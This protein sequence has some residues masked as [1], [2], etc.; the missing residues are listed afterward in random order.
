MSH[1]Y[2]GIDCYKCPIDLAIYQR[3]MWELKPRTV[4]V[5]TVRRKVGARSG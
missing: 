2:K 3:L 5:E 4:I 1:A